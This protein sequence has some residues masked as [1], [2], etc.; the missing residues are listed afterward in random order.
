V[1]C[2]VIRNAVGKVQVSNRLRSEKHVVKPKVVVVTICMYGVSN[3]FP[4][5]T[6]VLS[7]ASLVLYY[8]RTQ[9]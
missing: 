2:A 1:V 8:S 9:T 4:N 7:L 6:R 3:Q 5:G